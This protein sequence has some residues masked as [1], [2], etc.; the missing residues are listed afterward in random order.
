MIFVVYI[1]DVIGESNS[2]LL[3][4]VP[5]IFIYNHLVWLC[6]SLINHQLIGSYSIVSGTL[7]FDY[8]S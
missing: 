3:K 1:N 2:D 8:R 5:A 4:A 6:S 7:A